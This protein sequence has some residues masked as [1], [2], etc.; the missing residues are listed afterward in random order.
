MVN[1]S[2]LDGAKSNRSVKHGLW[3]DVENPKKAK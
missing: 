3:V 2:N 1:E